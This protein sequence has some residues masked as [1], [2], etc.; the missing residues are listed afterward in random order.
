MRRVYEENE[1]GKVSKRILTI[2]SSIFQGSQ[3]WC[4][5]GIVKTFTSCILPFFISSSSTPIILSSLLAIKLLFLSAVDDVVTILF[6]YTTSYF[7]IIWSMGRVTLVL[8]SLLNGWERDGDQIVEGLKGHQWCS[9]LMSECGLWMSS[10]NL[11]RWDGVHLEDEVDILRR[12]SSRAFSI[13][14][15][16]SPQPRDFVPCL[17]P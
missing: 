14:L 8:N 9:A 5:M 2:P 6:V 16:C 10:F 4:T 7:I 12:I 11:T 1:W 15:W 17:P 3:T 13:V